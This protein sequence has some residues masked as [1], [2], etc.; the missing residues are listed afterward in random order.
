MFEVADQDQQEFLFTIIKR[1]RED[2]DYQY[3]LVQQ[4]KE[5]IKMAP[6]FPLPE[7][8]EIIK[9]TIEQG[10]SKSKIKVVESVLLLG[11]LQSSHDIAK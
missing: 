2:K 4:L 11:T 9:E 3:L 8:Y 10:S 6:L 5:L 7:V 1:Y